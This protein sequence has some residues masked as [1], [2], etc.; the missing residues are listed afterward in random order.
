MLRKNL[1]ILQRNSSFYEKFHKKVLESEETK[2]VY[3][4]MK[5]NENIWSAMERKKSALTGRNIKEKPVVFKRYNQNCIFF[6]KKLIILTDEENKRNSIYK[7]LNPKRSQNW[8][9]WNLFI[10][11]PQKKNLPWKLINPHS[12]S[13]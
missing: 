11:S 5:E 7:N 10:L 13:T 8:V 2:V 4:Q 6:Q 3:D 9:S 12:K 1:S